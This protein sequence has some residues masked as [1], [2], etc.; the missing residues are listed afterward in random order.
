MRK[1][2]GAKYLCLFT[3]VG[4]LGIVVVGLMAVNIHLAAANAGADWIAEGNQVDAKLG[5]SASTAGDIN[6]DGYDDIIV[7]A[8]CY[9]QGE[10]NEGL[11]LVYYGGRDKTVAHIP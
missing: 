8:C 7:G 4:I 5:W 3:L 11:V 1:D 10:K 9:D 6:G 2:S